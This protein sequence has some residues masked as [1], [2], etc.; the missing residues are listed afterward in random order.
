VSDWIS[1]Y[2]KVEERKD[3]YVGDIDVEDFKNTLTLRFKPEDE[4]RTMVLNRVMLIRH[5]LAPSRG[6]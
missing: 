2:S 1:T 6:N 3:L 4:K 5:P